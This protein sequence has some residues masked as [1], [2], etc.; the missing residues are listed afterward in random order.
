[1]SLHR[2]AIFGATHRPSTFSVV[3]QVILALHRRGVVLLVEASL[4]SSLQLPVS[5]PS[6]SDKAP[7][8]IDAAISFGGD[9][10]FLRTLHRLQE[11]STPILAVNSGHMGFLTDLDAA[12][13]FPLVEDLLAGRYKIEERILLNIYAEGAYLG[14]A[15]NEVAIQ[16]RETGSMIDVATYLQGQYLAT[17]TGDGL[18]VATPS[19][20]TAYSLSLNGPIV[21]PRC[22]LLLLT[23]VA[24]HSLNMRPMAIPDD[25]LI[26]VNVRSRSSSY[27]VVVDGIVSN[28]SID[29]TLRIAKAEKKVRLIK[30]HD[31]PF[32]EVIRKKL[33]WGEQYKKNE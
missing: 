22:S 23:P 2:L 11:T 13:F 17:Y 15:F 10:T 14:S 24:P 20:S 9:G 27:M 30:L 32:A 31:K 1:M 12:E 19:G 4:L 5:L 18:I 28:L 6:F 8:D 25:A 33:L 3:E 21:D 29:T 26:T 7:Q 16:K